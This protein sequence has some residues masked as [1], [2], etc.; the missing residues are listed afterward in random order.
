MQYNARQ[1]TPAYWRN[2][3]HDLLVS[4]RALW[5]AMQNN[6]N[7]EVNCWATYKMLMRMSFKLLSKAHCVGAGIV[8]ILC[9][10]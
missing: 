1:N 7:L 5:V 4:A 9:M 6:S 2:K 8:L 10:T 3:S